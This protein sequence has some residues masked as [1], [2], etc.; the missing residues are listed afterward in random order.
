MLITTTDER[1]GAVNSR[2][3]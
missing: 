3:K 2:S 1:E